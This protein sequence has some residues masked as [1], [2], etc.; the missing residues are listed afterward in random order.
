MSCTIDNSIV[1]D[2]ELDEIRYNCN[3]DHQSN[4]TV[5]IEMTIGVV[6]SFLEQ[7]SPGVGAVTQTALADHNGCQ[8]RALSRSQI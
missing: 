8:V 3:E 7:G 1:C 6:P 4:D 2:K 5:Q